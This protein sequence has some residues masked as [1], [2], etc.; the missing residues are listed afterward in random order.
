VERGSLPERLRTVADKDGRYE[1]VVPVAGPYRVSLWAEPPATVPSALKQIDVPNADTF[2]L[3]F[4]IVEA[5]LRGRVL[6]AATGEPLAQ[7]S[8]AGVKTD[9]SGAFEA[10]VEPGRRTVSARTTTHL[11]GEATFDVAAGG[12]AEATFR[13]QRGEKLSVRVTDE[14]GK[15]VPSP[16]VLVASADGRNDRTTRGNTDGTADVDGLA[17]AEHTVIAGSETHGF[18]LR[19]GVRPGGEPVTITVRAAR[20]ITLLLKDEQGRPVIGGYAFF[21]LRRLDGV[22]MS[23][24]SALNTPPDTRGAVEASVPAGDV[25]LEVMTSYGQTMVHLD[26]AKDGSTA[27]VTLSARR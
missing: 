19:R 2:A 16:H 13:L 20:H 11:R 4:E 8:V 15:P 22:P 1:M 26:D 17:A 6:D 9:A 23:L 12:E 10:R 5:T 3:D 27:V 24:G 7:V 14:L 25:E 21:L 18:G